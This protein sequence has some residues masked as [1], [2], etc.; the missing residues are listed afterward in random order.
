MNTDNKQTS[1]KGGR[2][3]CV[4]L[5]FYN[6]SRSDH[7]INDQPKSLIELKFN[8][9]FQQQYESMEGNEGYYA[10]QY[11]SQQQ[12]SHFQQQSQES[13]FQQ[14]STYHHSSSSTMAAV[15]SST[16]SSAAMVS[17]GRTN[18][19]MLEEFDSSR[20]HDVTEMSGEVSDGVP[21]RGHLFGII[22]GWAKERSLDC[23]NPASGLPL[24]TVREFTQ[25]R[26]HVR[27]KLFFPPSQFP[28][29]IPVL[30]DK[31]SVE[32]NLVQLGQQQQMDIQEEE[33]R[34]QQSQRAEVLVLP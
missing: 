14:S 33:E 8:I 2:L 16:S 12:Q 21:V 1:Q 29:H 31:Y 18:A 5:N 23:V 30:E 11:R 25:P 20:F 19:G 3:S 34:Q 15:S 32:E 13:H 6:I 10:E 26:D 7:G 4:I 27:V 22:Q 24:V 9:K 17:S 28:S